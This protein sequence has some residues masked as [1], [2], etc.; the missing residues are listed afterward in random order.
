MS[1]NPYNVA[2]GGHNM[3]DISSM[4]LGQLES[5]GSKLKDLTRGNKALELPEGV[6]SSAM[7][8]YQMITPTRNA[9]AKQEFGDG[10]KDV[11]YNA[12]TQEALAKRLYN[13]TKG[14]YNRLAKTWTGLRGSQLLKDNPN[15]DWEQAK[16]EIARLESGGGPSTVARSNAIPETKETV[17]TLDKSLADP[18]SVWVKPDYSEEREQLQLERLAELASRD[19]NTGKYK[20]IDRDS[21]SDIYDN[22]LAAVDV[23][24]IASRKAFFSRSQIA[25]P[26]NRAT[27][28]ERLKRFGVLN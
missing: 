23:P 18:K 11:V 25:Q 20:D 5:V 16:E 9:L 12:E 27:I 6:G 13:Q 19:E 15:L 22:G 21:Y 8:K 14:D 24:N 3:G 2:T 7:G 4:T 17:V 26:N 1:F 10:W 28:K